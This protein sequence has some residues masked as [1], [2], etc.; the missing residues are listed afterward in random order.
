M[1]D[2]GDFF[3][4]DILDASGQG[5]SAAVLILEIAARP[6]DTPPATE[7]GPTAAYYQLNDPQTLP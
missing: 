6:A 2:G 7:P 4:Y 5:A 3:R 1:T